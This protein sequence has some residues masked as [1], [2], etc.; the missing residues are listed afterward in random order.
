MPQEREKRCSFCGSG[1]DDCKYLIAGPL[2]WICDGCV[3]KA[4][5]AIRAADADGGEGGLIDL[6]DAIENVLSKD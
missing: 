5:H 3:E 1:V 6:F 4:F 2:V